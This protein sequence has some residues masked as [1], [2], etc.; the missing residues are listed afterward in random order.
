[1]YLKKLPLICS[2][3]TQSIALRVARKS[4]AT[5]V[6]AH[7]AS[8][9]MHRV[10]N[11][12]KMRTRLLLNLLLLISATIT[13]ATLNELDYCTTDPRL[14]VQHASSDCAQSSIVTAIHLP[15]IDRNPNHA[16]HDYLWAFTHY[17]LHCLPP[18]AIVV[19]NEPP[20]DLS[21][22]EETDLSHIDR[23]DIPAWGICLAYIITKQTLGEDKFFL[24][25]KP[26]HEWP[27]EA[28]NHTDLHDSSD[29]GNCRANVWLGVEPAIK[30]SSV[31]RNYRFTRWFASCPNDMPCKNG[32]QELPSSYKQAAFQHIRRQTHENFH[33]KRPRSDL[34]RIKV[35]LYDR[36]DTRRRQWT[37]A[38]L[39]YRQLV[40]NS[41][42]SV[43]YVRH[44]PASFPQQV[45][46][47]AWPDILIAPHGAAQ[48]NTVFMRRKTYIIEI[49]QNCEI[50]I[51]LGRY[52]PRDWTGWHAK[53][54]DLGLVYAQ[55]HEADKP[56]R[57][58]GWI[59]KSA[60]KMN[61]RH[62]VRPE[63]IV[64]LVEEAVERLGD[65]EMTEDGRLKSNV[66][67]ATWVVLGMSFVAVLWL[68]RMTLRKRKNERV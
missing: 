42:L 27:Y 41:N 8:F 2:P 45:E 44:I 28:E 37:N 18:K 64:A 66:R 12:S 3:T 68:T 14:F 31:P 20:K 13:Q 40:N 29:R 48:A 35:L 23:Y 56:Y 15:I 50:E 26:K 11:G 47:F 24:L 49:W 38:E 4:D 58:R 5:I 6:L 21:L 19:V 22:C 53:H 25:E 43:R 33:I 1:M 60:K 51:G 55:C 16:L 17:I 65:I 7:H 59:A 39:A 67:I 57:T 9:L 36:S 62:K 54:L 34:K 30:R 32:L 61:G 46:L 10:C 52:E 63:E